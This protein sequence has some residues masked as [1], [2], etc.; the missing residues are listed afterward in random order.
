M[1][2]GYTKKL[3]DEKKKEFGVKTALFQCA[4]YKIVLTEVDRQ[5]I[6]GPKRLWKQ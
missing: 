6:M 5:H 3:I 1:E 4:S 2:Y